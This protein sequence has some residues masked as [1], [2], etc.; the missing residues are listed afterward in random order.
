MTASATAQASVHHDRRRG[1]EGEVRQGVAQPV[2]QHRRWQTGVD[3]SHLARPD[4]GALAQDRDHLPEPPQQGGAVASLLQDRRL[5][6]TAGHPSAQRTGEVLR[7]GGGEPGP[8]AGAPL[9]GV[10]IA[11]RPGSVS[12]SP[13]P[14]SSP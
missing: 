11:S 10:R 5:T 4:L 8:D 2:D 1:T 7:A 13:I 12:R 9:H 3:L 6:T 14:I